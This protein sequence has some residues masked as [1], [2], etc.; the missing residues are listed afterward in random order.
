MPIPRSELDRTNGGGSDFEVVPRSTAGRSTT[1]S[2]AL[3][4]SILSNAQ[5][6]ELRMYLAGQIA[7]ALAIYCI[8]EVVIF[9]EQND[10]Q[11]K[12][13]RQ[14]SRRKHRDNSPFNATEFFKL[15][16]EYLETPQ[17]LR[18]HMFPVSPELR[19][20]GLLNPLALPSHV[21]R[22]DFCRWREGIAVGRINYPRNQNRKAMGTDGGPVG[23]DRGPPTRFVD[24][25]Q[26]RLA[27]IDT[28]VSVGDRVTIDMEQSGPEYNS[29]PGKYLFGRLVDRETPTRTESLYWGYRVRVAESLSAVFSNS[30]VCAKGYDL[31]IGTSERGTQITGN[32]DS[33]DF[34]LPEFSHV[35]IVFGGV[36]GLE[37]SA[38]GDRALESLGIATA[39]ADEGKGHNIGDLFDFYVNTCPSQGS[40]TIRTEEAI[41]ISLAALQPHLRP[42]QNQE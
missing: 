9:E 8:D 13:E 34:K 40:R 5:S 11:T 31:T 16:L 26:E 22:D 17:Y 1:V 25:G 29:C 32:A 36:H 38:V 35:L 33:S 24:I 39:K 18:K 23:F 4:S 27:E 30:V 37:K 42:R 14:E 2:I 6:P 3:P 15:V 10:D 12:A 28:N 7:R 41:L 19:F 21:A 20:V